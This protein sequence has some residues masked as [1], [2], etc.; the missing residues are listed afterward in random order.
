[1][2]EHE[3]E[4]VLSKILIIYNEKFIN[5]IRTLK[6]DLDVDILSITDLERA[7]PFQQKIRDY[8]VFNQ[9]KL[10]FS[11]KHTI[12]LNDY[13][14]L[15]AIAIC[16]IIPNLSLYK[17]FQEILNE[18]HRYRMQLGLHS[19]S[20]DDI[21]GTEYGGQGFK[22]VCGKSCSPENLFIIKNID[23][24]LKIFVGCDCAE[25]TRF[26]NPNEIKSV[27]ALKNNDPHYKKLMDKSKMQNSQK[28]IEK[29][30]INL[31][32]M[33]E[34]VE[35]MK[36]KFTFIGG[37]NKENRELAEL[38]FAEKY[39]DVRV[40]DFECEKC[41][42]CDQSIKYCCFLAEIK[43]NPEDNDTIL[44]T[45]KTCTD[46]LGKMP[47][48]NKGICEDCGEKHRN[49]STNLCNICI[50]KEDCSNC[51][52]RELCDRKGRCEHCQQF[53]YCK[54]CDKIKVSSPGWFCNSCFGEKKVRCECG[55]YFN[56]SKYYTKCYDCNH[57]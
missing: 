23:T 40:E 17:S 25:K 11:K 35:S 36:Q 47:K 9:D 10:D 16:I 26:I 32:K 53:N 30:N 6:R 46:I 49:R 44:S 5:F 34:N 27:Q 43:D 13:P 22:C 1:M 48:N 29:M 56:K 51:G 33:G 28:H 7:M 14:N 41:E 2:F 52:K 24:D 31:K 4:D 8:I 15:F 3:S 18:S 19:S 45:C 20:N 38:Y 42:I 12:H 54:N 21:Y 37:N 57:S 55:K 50:K 39:F